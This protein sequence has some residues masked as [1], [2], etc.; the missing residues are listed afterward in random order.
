MEH[1]EQP[2]A[3]RAQA[4][5]TRERAFDLSA[6]ALCLDFANTLDARRDPVPREDLASYQDLVE[7]ARQ[8]GAVSPETAE[9]LAE[10]GEQRPIDARAALAKAIALRE[11]IFR[12]MEAVAAERDPD[13]DDLAALNAALSEALPYGRVVPAGEGF[14]WRWQELPGALD[15]MLWPVAHSAMELLTGG[16]LGRLRECAADDCG[17]LFIDTTRNHSRIWCDMKTCG[18]RAK[19]ARYRERHDESA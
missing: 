5:A 10:L 13:A 12:I 11:T 17:W 4:P 9:R 6:G 14:D 1:R 8:S 19:V 3:L 18:N 15:Q 16:D 2:A 7:F